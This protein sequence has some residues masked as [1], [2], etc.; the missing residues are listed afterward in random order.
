MDSQVP[1]YGSKTVTLTAGQSIAI[2]ARGTAK[3]YQIGSYTNQPQS[4]ALIGTVS[5][6]NFTTGSQTTFG[7]YAN[8]AT[9]VIESQ[10]GVVS[11]NIGTAPKVE[12]F[13]N[14][15]NQGAVSAKTTTTT[16]TVAELL[17]L[18][19]TATHSAGATQTY[20]LPT[21]TLLDAAQSWAVG[22]SFDWNLINLSTGASNTITLAAGT[23]HTIVGLAV[24]QSN[25]A[26]TGALYG[27]SASFRTVK[28]AANTFVTYRLA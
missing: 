9:L 24:V 5:G 19:I 8:G 16:L 6:S 18:I 21:G 12:F 13:L 14:Q 11:Y 26:T 3:V 20:T 7:P 22:D 4:P 27:S 25:D 17:S 28:T 10:A 2:F 23:G 1:A 15:G